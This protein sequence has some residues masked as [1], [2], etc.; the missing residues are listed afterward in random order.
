MIKTY[1]DGIVVRPFQE[2]D[3]TPEYESWFHDQEVCKYNSHG[4]MSHTFDKCILEDID[5]FTDI[6]WAIV[7]DNS[8][9]GFQQKIHIGNVA[10][11]I[12]WINRKAEFTCIFGEKEYW[13]KGICTR[14]LKLAIDH[15]LNKL[16][17]HKIWL[18]T[19]QGNEGMNR[20]AE[21]AG[22]DFETSMPDEL[23]IEG[24]YEGINRWSI[25]GN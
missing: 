20:V 15:G 3:I 13:G 4:L 1:E 21:K 10:L 6:I 25:Y 22:M 12:D 24:E 17:L 19:A 8:T 2:A 18:G 9:N 16:N 5:P 14:I 23:F 11:N 7:Q